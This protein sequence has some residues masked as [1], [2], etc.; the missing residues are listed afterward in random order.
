[1]KII[2]V[3]I[4]SVL[5]LT[6]CGSSGGTSTPPA[7]P[8]PAAPPPPPPE[9]TFEER[10]ANLGRAIDPNRLQGAAHLD[11]KRI[12]WLVKERRSGGGRTQGYGCTMWA[13][14]IGSGFT[15]CARLGYAHG[16]RSALDCGPLLRRWCADFIERAPR[17]RTLIMITS[18][19]FGSVIGKT[20]PLPAPGTWAKEGLFSMSRHRG[21][22][23]PVARR[24]PF[25]SAGSQGPDAAGKRG[26]QAHIAFATLHFSASFERLG[27]RT[28]D[29]GRRLHWRR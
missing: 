26:W 24:E 29:P 3:L 10:L 12:R 20:F 8:P 23:E 18:H 22:S 9:P 16:L 1:M 28:P 15:R 19:S 11:L 4:L 6:A 5:A 17:R 7:P 27:H 21:R 14:S 13:I 2:P 25:R